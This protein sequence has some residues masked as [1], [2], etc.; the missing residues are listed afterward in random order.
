[1]KKTKYLVA[2][3]LLMGATT[4]FTSCIDNDEPA[5][6]TDLRG[7]KAELI[8]AKAAVELAKVA[9]EEAK[10]AYL[11]ACV[12]AKDLENKE[13]ELKL[14][15]QEA[16]DALEIAIAEGKAEADIAYWKAQLEVIEAQKQKAIAEAESAMWNAK[17][18]SA[19]AQEQYEQALRDIEAAKLTLTD[20]EQKILEA[21]RELVENAKTNLETAEGNV[22]EAVGDYA[23]AIKEETV[24]AD[25]ISLELAVKTAQNTVS[26]KELAVKEAQETYDKDITTYEGWANEV[27]ALEEKK[28]VQDTLMSNVNIEIAKIKASQEYLAAQE[29][30]TKAE[31]ALTKGKAAKFT[32]SGK[33]IST[34]DKVKEVISDAGKTVTYKYNEDKNVTYTSTH[35][36]TNG[37]LVEAN[38]TNLSTVKASI[39]ALKGLGVSD[40]DLAWSE[41]LLKDAQE[42]N[43]TAQTTYDNAYEDWEEAVEKYKSG[44]V[45]MTYV[46]YQNKLGGIQKVLDENQLATVTSVQALVLSSYTTFYNEMTAV[47]L[48]IKVKLADVNTFD[49]LIKKYTSAS[50]DDLYPNIV[51]EADF[52]SKVNPL[53]KLQAASAALY[54]TLF[55]IDTDKPRLTP[56]TDAEKN[57]AYKAIKADND[58]SA[59]YGALGGLLLSQIKLQTA[60]DIMSCNEDL[61]KLKTDL[62]AYMAEIMEAVSTNES[63]VKLL[64][65]AVKTAESER[66]EMTKEQ[67]EELKAIKA[68]V[69]EYNAIIGA[70]KDEM[71]K[72]DLSTSSEPQT[73]AGIKEY[74]QVY[75]DKAE[76][77]LAEAKKNLETA[78][79]A[80]K[81]FDEGL[82][83]KTYEK[84]F[85]KDALDRAKAAY[86]RAV[87]EYNDA[88]ATLDSVLAQFAGKVD[89]DALTPVK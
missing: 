23:N 16:L 2:A 47:G 12:T 81:A 22:T 38:V 17:Q 84:Q 78:E 65:D 52:N 57:E 9:Q 42:A 18:A 35:D 74:L 19:K 80:L 86:D 53:S 21:A 49:K 45:T 56:L 85:A 33:E 83:D 44:D 69:T 32:I 48:E 13:K 6:I 58:A 7:A 36:A 28:A 67:E 26:A 60:E 41:S 8:R 50:A 68:I 40:E 5:G 29:K 1:M 79:N 54:G 51:S 25:R 66:D 76:K 72:F 14:K 27:E 24:V 30:V 64:A 61:A 11:Q 82:Y 31:Q 77:E 20:A 55:D 89:G 59:N 70:I 75:I 3:L 63:G 39:N 62:E 10:A 4:T 71:I 87:K 88:L 37:K 73:V 43:K 15:K 46:D 34:T